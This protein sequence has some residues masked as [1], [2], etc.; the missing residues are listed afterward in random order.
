MFDSDI[1]LIFVY[2]AP[3]SVQSSDGDNPLAVSQYYTRL[4]RRF[5]SSFTALTSEGRLYEIDIRLR[6]S[7]NDGPISSSLEAFGRYYETAAWIFEFM[8]LTRA[9]VISGGGVLAEKVNAM[10]HTFLCKERDPVM[11][12]QDV[13]QL[14]IKTDQVHHSKDPWN[15]KYVRGGLMDVEFIVQYLQLINAHHYPQILDLN[16]VRC[17]EKMGEAGVI[18]TKESQELAQMTQFLLD[19]QTLRRIAFSRNM[20]MEDIPIGLKRFIVTS[21]QKKDFKSLEAELITIEK[22]VLSYFNHFISETAHE[23]TKRSGNE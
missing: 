12:A 18:S 21:M 23:L 4:S 10:I 9:R 14:R 7:G 19:V 6:P 13:L 22:N 11:V 17:F 15:V 5:I 3:S 2:D 16:T 1:D 20:S 8:A